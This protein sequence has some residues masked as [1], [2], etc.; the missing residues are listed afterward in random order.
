MEETQTINNPNISV[1]DV[2]SPEK[3]I[4]TLQEKDDC[5]EDLIE[6][7]KTT[8]HQQLKKLANIFLSVENFEIEKIIELTVSKMRMHRFNSTFLVFTMIKSIYLDSKQVDRTEA[9]FQSVFIARFR[10][11]D[12]SIRAMCVQFLCEWV[13]SSK[14]LRNA[15]YIKYIGWSL[16]DKNDSVRRKAVRSVFKMARF[17]KPNARAPDENKAVILFVEKFSKRL[18]EIAT[19]D[20]NLNIQKEC[21][22]TI[23]AIYLKNE[24][25]FGTENILSVISND[26]ERT[27]MKHL[28]MKRLCP[29]GIWDL[30]TLHE[31]LMK[32][33]P[34]VFKNMRLS[35]EDVNSLVINMTEFIK[36]KSRCCDSDSLCL[37]GILN[38]ME[39]ESDPQVFIDLLEAVKDNGKNIK[40]AVSALSKV[41][42][43]SQYPGSTFRIL[44]HLRKLIQTEDS[45]IV[46][47]VELLRKLEE[48]FSLQVEAIISEIKDKY[49]LPVVK[50]FDIS[51]SIGPDASALIKCYTALWKILKEDYEWIEN[52]NFHND[53][54]SI[55]NTNIS[56]INNNNINI[57]NI[58]YMV[59][60][61][62]NN[63]S[64][65]KITDSQMI[66]DDMIELMDFAMFFHSK[67]DNR[68]PIDKA[69]DPFSSSKILFEKLISFISKNFTF[70]SEEKCI[71][72]FKMIS[73]GQFTYSAKVL[74]EYCSE[75]T[76]KSFIA[77]SKDIKPLL[78]G[79]LE[80]L[81]DTRINKKEM[82]SNGVKNHSELSKQIA[83]K[84]DRNEK[85][86]QFFTLL[87]RLV[88]RTD[89]LDTVL[90][91]FIVCLNIN[92]C[93]VLENIAPK[94][95]FKSQLL[96]KCKISKTEQENITFI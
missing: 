68:P 91:N 52:I 37:F 61:Q 90:I 18:L 79:Y 96:R 3:I 35:P 95:K 57:S 76:L 65:M 85:D 94:S 38:V 17:C 88:D 54:T 15:E 58:D 28:V 55:N 10:D 25:L 8:T 40:M 11:V 47:F 22:K 70:D 86:R 43:Y 32:S 60:N 9:L 59:E 80:Y 34:H 14:A 13:C 16:N 41:S 62:T 66:S 7:I 89:L 78:L 64:N 71:R 42:S 24:S 31:I 67:T 19:K 45:F 39:F 73:I 77:Q 2:Y 74:F 6:I 69:V 27:E 23:L 30:E 63:Q 72:L 46:E 49:T 21:S 81:Q 5:T 50:Y 92:E 33:K 83:L 87:K 56:N 1:L 26:Q 12:P 53:T 36:N 29:E 48:D 4:K 20:C 44:D 82:N 51:D 93:I 84:V 75:E